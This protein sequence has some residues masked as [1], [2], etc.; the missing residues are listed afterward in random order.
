L[1]VKL[2]AVGNYQLKKSFGGTGNTHTKSIQQTLNGNFI[3]TGYTDS[4]NGD[5]SGNH[6]STDYWIA[7]LDAAG[8][9]Q[10]QNSLGGSN[11]DY[12]SSIQQTTDGGYIIAGSSESNDGDVTGHHGSYLDDYWIVKL[13]PLS[14]GIEE[15]SSNPIHLFPNPS[16]SILNIQ[17]SEKIEN[18]FIYNVLGELVQTEKQNSFSV[19]KLKTGMYLVKIKTAKG[20]TTERFV[21]E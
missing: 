20:L 3:I 12:A 5:V 2:D 9:I 16:S 8:T 4:N 10:W 13:A 15:I 18:I 6:G 21:K 17:S 14:T 7:S 19:E 1:V 11:Y